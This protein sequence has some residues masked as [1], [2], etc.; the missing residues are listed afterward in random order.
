M[1][2]KSLAIAVSGLG[3]MGKRH[4]LNFLQRVPRAKLVAVYTPDSNEVSWARINLEPYGVKIYSSYESLL[5][6]ADLDAVVIA[7]ITGVHA[8]QSIAAIRA[9]K[10]V[11]CEKPLSTSVEVSQSVVDEA[12]KHPELKVM[13][14]FSRR[15]DES[16]RNAAEHVQKGGIGEVA[17]IRSQTCDRFDETGSFLKC[18][19]DILTSFILSRLTLLLWLL[20]VPRRTSFWWYIRRL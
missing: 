5:S 6:H 10:H 9:G 12:K 20:N 16:Y 11:L 8:E 3:R 13:C 18:K 7:T 15:F 14:G 2:P 1:S 17:V 19:F 4:A